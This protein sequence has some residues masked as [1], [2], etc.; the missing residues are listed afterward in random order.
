MHDNNKLIL[1]ILAI[2]WLAMVNILFFWVRF[3]HSSMVNRIVE[4]MFSL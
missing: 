3:S 1:S 4:R 2:L